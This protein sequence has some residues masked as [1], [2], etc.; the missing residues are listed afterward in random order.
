MALTL[1]PKAKS[2]LDMRCLTT[3]VLPAPEGAEKMM[4]RPSP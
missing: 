3:V 4:A 1:N 2:G